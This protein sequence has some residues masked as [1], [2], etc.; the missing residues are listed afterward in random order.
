[1]KETAPSP[2]WKRHGRI[3]GALAAL[4]IVAYCIHSS[5]VDDAAVWQYYKVKE[6]RRGKIKKAKEQNE[7][8]KFSQER[9]GISRNL[10]IEEADGSRRQFSLKAASA[11]AKASK[12]SKKTG[13]I[14]V[15]D[16]PKGW[17]QEE[18]YWEIADTG[19]KVVLQND[20]WVRSAPPHQKIPE[21]RYSQI[22]PMQRVRFFDALSGEWNPTTNKMIATSAFFSILK[23]SGHE[24]PKSETEGEVIAQGTANKIIFAFDKAGRKQVVCQGAKIHLNQGSNK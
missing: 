9:T 1:M 7:E 23:V 2:L 4:L 15:Y 11:I 16:K 21:N 10:W 13:L 6:S 3:W 22:T 17:F 18:L 5:K 24:L 19:E 8:V 12:S 14:E 20:L